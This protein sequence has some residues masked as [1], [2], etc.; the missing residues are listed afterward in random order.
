MFDTTASD[1][2][3]VKHHNDLDEHAFEDSL[4][5]EKGVHRMDSNIPA[6]IFLK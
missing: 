2:G 4:G 5:G 6:Q 1:R 3:V